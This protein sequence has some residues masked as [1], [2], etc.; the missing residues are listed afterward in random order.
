M[1]PIVLIPCYNAG[2]VLHDTVGECL[3][4]P[5]HELDVLVI[6][7]GCTDSSEEELAPL[8]E[9]PRLRVVSYQPNRGKG[10][11]VLLGAE[12]AA[13]EGYTHLLT[14]DSDGQHPVS[15][16]PDYLDEAIRHPRS[17]VY[18]RPVFDQHAPAARV[19][20]RR[21]S[22]GLA[23]AETL[24][25]GVDDVLFGMRCYPT[26]P[27]LRAMRSTRFGRRYDFDTEIAVRL[28][29]HGVNARNLPTP[30]RYLSP[31]EGGVSHFQ[32]LRDNLLLTGMHLRLVAGL[33]PRLPSLLAQRRPPANP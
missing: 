2:P 25:W 22:N 28:S 1:K 29:W 10:H 16:I 7:D 4:L 6:L 8:R 17:V 5:D 18:G 21:I 24:N 11:A 13:L 19:Q 14:L 3:T 20:G 33:L 23:A 9:N 32:Y 27:F 31:E 15:M 12:E 30:V 26:E